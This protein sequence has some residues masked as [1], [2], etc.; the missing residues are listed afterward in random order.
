MA[1]LHCSSYQVPALTNLKIPNSAAESP[2]HSPRGSWAAPGA[3]TLLCHLLHG[4]CTF[5][6]LLIITLPF[7]IFFPT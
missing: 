2:A 6:L 3:V 4:L 5:G 1:I 7:S